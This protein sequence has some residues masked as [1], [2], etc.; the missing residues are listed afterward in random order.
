MIFA[1]EILNP[2]LPAADINNTFLGPELNSATIEDFLAAFCCPV[3]VENVI[4][5]T[6]S[7]LRHVRLVQS[8]NIIETDRLEHVQHADEFTINYEFGGACIIKDWSVRVSHLCHYFPILSGKWV[9]LPILRLKVMEYNVDNEALLGSGI[10]HIVFQGYI[11][12]WHGKLV[13]HCICD[14]CIQPCLP[15]T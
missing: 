13:Y 10:L 9:G 8:D 7:A 11:C 15:E 14:K 2:V 5:L 6:A 12:T 4:P 3:R 1:E